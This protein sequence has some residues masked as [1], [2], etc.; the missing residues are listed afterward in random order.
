MYND[1]SNQICRIENIIDEHIERYTHPGYKRIIDLN[2]CLH[3]YSVSHSENGHFVTL[4]FTN[5]FSII[6]FVG[7]SVKKDDDI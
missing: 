4:N 7:F 3:I 6:V 1:V 5:K 2:Q